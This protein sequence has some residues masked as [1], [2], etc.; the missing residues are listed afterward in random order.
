MQPP[1]PHLQPGPAPA[2][3]TLS[4]QPTV[5]TLFPPPLLS[6]RLTPPPFL[7]LTR[8]VEADWQVL[9]RVAVK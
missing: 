2:T 3:P 7:A 9:A 4:S 6:Y 1:L 8:L 5:I